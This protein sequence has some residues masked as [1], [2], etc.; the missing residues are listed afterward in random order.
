VDARFHP[1]ERLRNVEFNRDWNLAADVPA[2]T[3]TLI[4]GG[5]QLN[6]TK[7][8][9]IRYDIINYRRGSDYN[10]IR[11]TI[12]QG[13]TIKGWR[14]NNQLS[15]TATSDSLSK[16]YFFR[17]RSTYRGSS[18]ISTI[19]LLALTIPFSAARRKTGAPI[20]CMRPALRLKTSSSRSNR[21]RRS[22]ISGAS[23][24]YP[25]QQLSYGKSLIKAD[26]SQNVNLAGELAK[27]P[28]EQFRWNITY[29]KLD[30]LRSGITSQRA[31]N[32]LLGRLEYQVN[33]WKGLLAGNM[34]YETGSGQ[35]QKLDYSYLQVPADRGSTR[36]STTTTTVYRSLMN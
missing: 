10:G 21:R 12:S 15:Y 29:R 20:R 5:L 6:D 7:N 17:P 26:R 19:T 8:A 36:G 34:L 1:L 24:I 13:Q 18:R 4:S 25:H 33:E 16:G 22:G 31:D 27:N 3:E 28:R 32:S 9:G 11:N 30:I 2:A 23:L 14:L 35:E